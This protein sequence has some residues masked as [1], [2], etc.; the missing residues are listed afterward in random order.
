VQISAISGMGGIGKSELALQYA[1]RHMQSTYPGG[2]VWLKAREDIGL[3]ILDWARLYANLVPP[4]NYQ[5]AEQ[6]KW[7]WQKWWN[8]TTL[9]VFDDVQQYADIAEF[10]PPPSSQFRTLLASRQ[11]FSSPV[12]SYE[13]KVLSGAAAIKLLGS[14]APDLRQRVDAD[15]A[16]TQEI[17]G[18]LGYLPLG[19][20]LVGRYF[21]QKPDLTLAEVWAKL[22]AQ[23]LNALALQA[24]DRNMTATLG[25]IAAFELSWQELTPEA[26]QVAA[27]LS[28]FA[29]AEM[30]WQLVVDCLSEWDAEELENLRDHELCRAS[31]LTRTGQGRYELHQLLREFFALKLAEMPEQ[32]EFTIKFAQALTAV[33]KTIPQIVT[34]EQQTNLKE[35]IPHLI[36][37][38]DFSRYLPDGDKITC[39]TRLGMFYQTQSQFTTAKSWYKKAL[40]ISEEQLGANHPSTATSLNN[41]AAL[42]RSI[43]KY[44]EAEPLYMRSL[45]IDR[46]VYG[47]DHP[48]IAT[49]MNNLAGLYRSIGKYAEAEPLYVRSLAIKEEKLGANHPDTAGSL[50]NL[51]GLY[52][53]MGRYA[54]AEPLYV[55]SL[56]IKEEKL[57]ANH[58]DTATSLNNLA[59]LYESMGRYA[60][61]EPLYV[62]SLAIKEEQLGAN[63]PSTATSLNN[64]AGLYKSI[65]RYAEAEPLYV[66]SLAIREEQLGAN[67]PDTAGS[68]NNLASLYESTGRYKEAESLYVRSLAIREKELGAN[69]P[70]TATSLNN[71]AGLYNSMG[72]YTEAEPLYERSLSI[73][74][75]ELGANHPSIATSLNNL[76]GLYRSIGRY[77]EAETLYVRALEILEDKLGANHPNT[78]ACLKNLQILRQ[79]LAS[80]QQQIEQPQT[81]WW[82]RLRQKFR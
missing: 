5:I 62:R 27:R 38:T 15:L 6:I 4:E 21:A 47:E 3:Q 45:A 78:Q 56:A 23:R 40:T 26:K 73:M 71:L 34:V 16:T 7:C 46:I 53:S 18:W 60:E 59:G 42:Y 31:L 9:I 19:L 35:I 1:D 54:E 70:D 72:R 44:A 75:K 37:A 28:L 64:L 24:A 20:E 32:E 65:G 76:A 82:Q 66:R 74:E 52:E 81:T 67:H 48:E 68:L 43:G 30:P 2:V 33:A 8:A 58:P 12:R 14:F 50:N 79:Q 11:K 80:P 13:I 25:V 17:C 51:A 41:L 61:A 10:L 29:L 39:C 49:D 77:K 36:A 55:R 69:H 63:H 22:Q 57:G